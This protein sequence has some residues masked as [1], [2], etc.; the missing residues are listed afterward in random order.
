MSE[1][2]YSVLITAQAEADLKSIVTYI[3][4]NDSI[5]AANRVL[6]VLQERIMS[7]AEF[8]EQGAV[9]ELAVLGINRYRELHEFRYRIIYRIE[10]QSVFI[11]LIADGRRNISQLLTER[12]LIQE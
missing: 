12:I 4:T 1:L 7:L 10:Q 2:P 11:L 3:T 9:S 8:P 6:M 5:I